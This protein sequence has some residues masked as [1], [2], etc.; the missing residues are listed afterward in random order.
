LPEVKKE[1]GLKNLK[2]VSFQ[3]YDKLSES[4]K[5][6]TIELA[7]GEKIYGLGLTQKD[8]D[9]KEAGIGYIK[10][11]DGKAGKKIYDQLSKMNTTSSL[12]PEQVYKK[13]IDST[14][15]AAD[16]MKK[17]A[18]EVAKLIAGESGK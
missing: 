10:G 8:L 14:K 12:T 4:E 3:D 17:I 6:N 13:G 18:S 15:S 11:K 16:N 5:E 2:K 9:Q 7:N 1:Y